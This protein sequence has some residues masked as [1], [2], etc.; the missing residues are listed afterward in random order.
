[1]PPEPPITASSNPHNLVTKDEDFAHL[2]RREA[3]GSAVVWIRLGNTTNKALWAALEP[4]LPDLIDSLRRG[5]RLIEIAQPG[6]A[7]QRG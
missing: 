6:L 3:T 4:L 5:E 1:M 7:R 2:A